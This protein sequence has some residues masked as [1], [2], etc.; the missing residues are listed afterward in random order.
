MTT[1]APYGSWDSPITPDVLVEN[2]V[3]LSNPLG[4]GEDLYWLE[5]RPAEGGRY[6]IVRRAPDGRAEDALPEGFSARTLVH[7]YGGLCYGAAAG[8]LFFSNFSDQRL[9]RSAPGRAPQPLTPAPAEP[10]SVRYADPALSP[11]GRWIVCVRERHTKEG[12]VNEIVVLP[13]DGTA[14]PAIVAEGHD[15]FSAPR[16]SPSGDR[17]AW[18]TWEH[19]RMPWDGT[20]LWEAEVTEGFAVSPPRKVAGGSEE[21]ITQPR[22]SPSGKLL[23]VSDRTGWWNLYSGDG[24]LASMEAEFSG[25]DWV[26]GQ[27]SYTFLP[28]GS[29]VAT[30]SESGLD[31]V[32]VLAPGEAR[33]R[34]VE[35]PFT[36]IDSIGP[37]GSGIAAIAGSATEA[38][39]V[40]EISIPEGEVSIL[41]R[42]R[43]SSVPAGYLSIPR[44]IEFPT[45]GGLTAHALFY[46]PANADFTGPEDEKPPLIVMS[47]GGPTSATSS[48][49]N[50]GIQFWTSRGLAVVDVN[51]G[52]STGYGR[53]Y[54]DRLKGAWGVVDVDDCVNAAA[55]LAHQGEVDGSRMAIRGGSAGG[56]TTLCALTFRDVFACGASL[57]G[58]ADAGALAEDTHKFESRYLD[59]LIGPWPA[60]RD[61]YEERSPIFHTDRLSTPVILFQ[62]LEDKVVPPEQAEMMARALREKGVPFAHIVYP[63][64]QHG[65]RKAENIKRTCEAELYFYGRILGFD[66][67]GEPAPVPIENL[68][69]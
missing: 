18:L 39:A 48:V 45:E 6:V 63:D 65:F 38:P 23:Y 3:A 25:P 15:F 60:D 35:V 17:L 41:R 67:A 32:G 12:V 2:V 13:T 52:G 54:R 8:H 26:F 27:S 30:W 42:S 21:S 10:L 29:L 56:Y 69:D 59:G 68:A 9:Y 36:A 22:Y 50:Y 55:W 46:P 33:F 4:D 20:E 34:V 16:V 44:P 28:D 7:E 64:E 5:M 53:A 58:V 40:V 11:D 43:E 14:E 1:V 31:H 24:V 57:Y 19:P 61:L 49:L 62:G 47:H 51:Y 37:Y 66:P